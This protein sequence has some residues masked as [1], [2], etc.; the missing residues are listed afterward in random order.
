[1]MDGLGGGAREAVLLLPYRGRDLS[2][3]NTLA[4]PAGGEEGL[5]WG[6]P[7]LPGVARNPVSSCLSFLVLGNTPG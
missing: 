2:R 1:M 7:I 4:D 6:L 5:S 3:P